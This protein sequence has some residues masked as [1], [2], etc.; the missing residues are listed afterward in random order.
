MSPTKALLVSIELSRK[1]RLSSEISATLEVK[2]LDLLLESW[3][4]QS[5]WTIVGVSLLSF[6][7]YPR[8]GFMSLGKCQH[9]VTQLQSRRFERRERA[10]KTDPWCPQDWIP[11]PASQ[12]SSASES[13]RRVCSSASTV[14]WETARGGSEEAEK[15][16]CSSPHRSISYCDSDSSV[17]LVK[18]FESTKETT[19][20]PMWQM[21]S[22]SGTDKPRS[23]FTQHVQNE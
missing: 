17:I 1:S 9:A 7:W 4:N 23:S 8:P 13:H 15:S 16:F 18:N 22:L 2:D 19:F 6:V 11:R 21:N 3:L 12:E 5:E 10:S 14:I 20:S